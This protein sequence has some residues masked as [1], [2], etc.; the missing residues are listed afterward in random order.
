M[1]EVVGVRFK[2]AGRIYYFDPAGLDLKVDDWV[3]VET[4]RGTEAGRVVIGPKQVL[5][6]EITEPLKPVLRKAEPRDL[7]QMAY[8][9][10]RE[11]EALSRCAQKVAEHGLPMKLVAAEYNYDGSRITFYFT[12]EGRVDFR[13][14]VRDLASTF[15]TRI[16][17]RQIG[18]R[19]EVKLFGGFGRCGRPLCCATFLCEFTPVSIK[20]AKEQDL[21]LNP[22]KISGICGRLLCCLASEH[23]FYCEAKQRLPKV[24]E[25][26]GT[27]YGKGKVVGTNVLKETVF[28][29]L[30]S[31]TTIEIDS[32]KVERRMQCT[33]LCSRQGEPTQ[34]VEDYEE[35][36]S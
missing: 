4:V 22:T 19:D 21:P 32:K 17:L 26:V 16:E 1:P 14:L 10:S 25:E 8:F 6:S 24:G 7:Q 36:A 28:V 27:P 13:E 15:R 23:Q 2:R 31:L 11:R 20:M 29:Q 34:P 3:I 12:A 9:K 33:A 30:E 5:E 35:G 18:V